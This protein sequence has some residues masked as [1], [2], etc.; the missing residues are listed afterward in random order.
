MGGSVK[1]LL[2]ASLLLSTSAWGKPAA[3]KSMRATNSNGSIVAPL[4]PESVSSDVK[5]TANVSITTLGRMIE[6]ENLKST[7]GSAY[8]NPVISAQYFDWFKFNFA[9]LGIFGE[10]AAQNFLS[11]SD[12]GATNIIIIDTAGIEL[13]PIKQVTLGLG[14]IGYKINPLLSAMAAG[15]SPAAEQKIELENNK[16]TFKFSLIGNEAIPSLGVNKTSVDQEKS[17]FF[18]SGTVMLE[19]KFEPVSTTIKLA[20]TQF[21]FGNLPY[22]TAKGA[23]TAGNSV[24]SV[25]GVGDNMQ[26]VIGFAG[27]ES[28]AVMETE[29]VPNLKTIF[30]ASLIKNDRA[31]E[32]QNQGKIG[33]A[34]IEWTRGNLKYSPGVTFF[35]VQSDVTPATFTPMSGRYNNRKGYRAGMEIEL[36]KQKIIF[37]GSYVKADVI[38]KTPFLFDREIYNLGLEVNYDLF[39]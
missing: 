26:F 7:V 2:F 11:E 30:K 28:A 32:G 22:N 10:G 36:V 20:A 9:L 35:E 33:R 24:S 6:D 27:T 38:E 13:T 29:W 39:K 12:G 3:T 21:R 19:G 31:F 4:P 18:L 15:T 1:R 34:G 17:P 25:S 23:L 14:I 37:S 16:E 5:Y 8:V